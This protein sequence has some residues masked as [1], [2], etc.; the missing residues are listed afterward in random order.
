LSANW[1]YVHEFY[2]DWASLGGANKAM[3][4]TQSLVDVGITHQMSDKR[5]ALS[6]DAKNIFN[7]QAFDNWALQKPGR[8]FYVKITYTLL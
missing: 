1:A 3:V 6:L 7:Q 4:P 2:R 5:L 8:A